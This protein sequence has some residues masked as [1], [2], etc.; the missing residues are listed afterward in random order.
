MP[1]PKYKHVSECER[2]AETKEDAGIKI[3]LR[4]RVPC[5]IK[6]LKLVSQCRT[7]MSMNSEVGAWFV[8]YPKCDRDA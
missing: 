7:N 8:F 2:A 1:I 3:R 4:N 5:V 6:E